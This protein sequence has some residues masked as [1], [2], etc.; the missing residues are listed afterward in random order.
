MIYGWRPELQSKWD[1]AFWVRGFCVETI[2]NITDKK[3]QKYIIEQEES[4]K[5]DSRS[6]AL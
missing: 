4:R 5:E 3:V 1:K 2:G 6:A